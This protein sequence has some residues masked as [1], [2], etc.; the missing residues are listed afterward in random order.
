MRY[1]EMQILVDQAAELL[2]NPPGPGDRDGYVG[3]REL[4]VD[5]GRQLARALGAD[6]DLLRSLLT[7][8]DWT[9]VSCRPRRRLLLSVALYSARQLT[10]DTAG[11]SAARPRRAIAG[12]IIAAAA[13][14]LLPVLRLN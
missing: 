11:R 2:P 12:D 3:W 4:T 13:D 10:G 14:P 9:P 8:D 6:P 1:E 5:T 7:D